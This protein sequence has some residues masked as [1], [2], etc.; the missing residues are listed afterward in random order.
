MHIK[1]ENGECCLCDTHEF[2]SADPLFARCVWT[3]KVKEAIMQWTHIH[4][5]A[6]RIDQVLLEIN[7]RH[8]SRAQKEI[9]AALW[10]AMVY[11]TWRAR[12]WKIYTGVNVQNEQV[13]TQIK[14]E[15]IDR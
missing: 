8:W 1:V 6:T 13:I 10:G 12:N 2:E 9:V 4:I 3:Q 5:Q 11:H 7:R 15:F 14:Q